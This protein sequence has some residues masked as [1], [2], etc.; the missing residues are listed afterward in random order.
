MARIVAILVVAALAAIPAA[1]PAA[2][3]QPLLQDTPAQQ[4]APVPQQAPT[5]QTTVDD[6][7]LSSRELALVG[8]GIVVLIGAIWF[9]ISR[10]ARRFTAGR[11][12]TA[13]GEPGAGRGGSA[14]RAARRSRRLSA[15]ER[16]RRKRGRAH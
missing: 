4:Q 11:V 6:G 13:D 5:T 16:R 9:V 14:T 3:P 8:L 7:S 12:R 2:D 15:E 1:A 10:D